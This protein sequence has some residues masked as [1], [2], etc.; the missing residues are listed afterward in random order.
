MVEGIAVVEIPIGTQAAIRCQVFPE[1]V[2]PAGI[3]QSV[4]K[5]SAG[6]VEYKAVAPSGIHVVAGAP[7]AFVD[8][9]YLADAEGGKAAGSVLL[10]VHA[11][12]SRSLLCIHDEL[13][14][15]KTF[16]QV[17]KAFFG[18][19]KEANAPK[20][21]ATYMEISKVRIDEQD[22]GFSVSRMLPGE[23]PALRRY[24]SIDA[25]FI[26]TSP[27]DV[28]FQ[29]TY[30]IYD[31]GKDDQL[32]SGTWVEGSAGEITLKIALKRDDSGKYKY[33]GE[34][35]GKPLQ[36]ELDTSKGLSTSVN[37]AAL[38]KK[39]LKAGAPFEETLYEYTPSIDP[40]ATIPVKYSHAKGAPP[41]QVVVQTGERVFTAE[42]DEDGM[43]KTGSF[44]FGKRKM[45][46]TREQVDGHL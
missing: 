27:K 10:A 18:S 32:L 21:A 38:L 46:I 7:A 40:T 19:F 41:R 5:G 44:D 31:F 42:I 45:V 25:A 15:R 33:A 35:S 8:T 30:T 36:G 39:K 28:M 23:K 22:V 11:R 17:S 16:E 4:I 20:S 1:T 3:I 14:Y 6:K 13:G 12:E 24:V 2:D 29:D 34:V 37:M 9:L 43:P 26:P